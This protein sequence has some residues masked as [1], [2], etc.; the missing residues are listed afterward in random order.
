MADWLRGNAA[1]PDGSW[2]AL[3]QK[4]LLTDNELR[5]AERSM[6][7]AGRAQRRRRF[8]VGRALRSRNQSEVACPR[9]P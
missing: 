6:E 9:T 3:F 1:L 5:H 8:G 2:E 4:D 7:C